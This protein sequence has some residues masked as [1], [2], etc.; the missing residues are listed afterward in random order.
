M[1]NS[2]NDVPFV[3]PINLTEMMTALLGTDRANGYILFDNTQIPA[4]ATIQYLVPIPD[5]IVSGR[6]V[7]IIGVP[8]EFAAMPDPDYQI[9]LNFTVDGKPFLSD[10]SM[11]SGLYTEPMNMLRDYALSWYAKD[12]FSASFTNNGGTTATISFRFIFATM[13]EDD[14]KKIVYHYADRIKD[15]LLE[16]ELRR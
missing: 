8:F 16:K 9:S 11:V 3:L 4:G 1:T 12:Y 13:L 10:T 6:T 2:L 15:W 14:Y 5:K 7:S